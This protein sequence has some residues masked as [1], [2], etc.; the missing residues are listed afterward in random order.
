M[1]CR[2]FFTVFA[3]VFALAPFCYCLRPW[4]LFPLVL[5]FFSSFVGMGERYC[6]A[7]N[8]DTFVKQAAMVR[9]ILLQLGLCE[10][11]ALSYGT[12][13]LPAAGCQGFARLLDLKSM[14]NSSASKTQLEYWP[15]LNGL[16]N[17]ICNIHF[18]AKRDGPF[19]MVSSQNCASIFC[20]N[21]LVQS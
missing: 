2:I 11:V 10:L 12:E 3:R 14:V 6:L 7:D 1:A 16:V 20:A 5:F 15:N 17:S 18:E 8:G 13:G 4:F 9:W 19:W 21:W